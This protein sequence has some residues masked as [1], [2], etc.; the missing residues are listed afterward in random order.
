VEHRNLSHK[1]KFYP[2]I[3]IL[4]RKSEFWSK[5]LGTHQFDLFCTSTIFIASTFSVLR[6]T[7]QTWLR[8]FW[9]NFTSTKT[10]LRPLYFDLFTS[11]CTS[12][13]II[14]PDLTK[15]RSRE[16]EV[17]KPKYAS[18]TR[19]VE[20]ERSTK[21]SKIWNGWSTEKV[22]VMRTQNSKFGQKSIFS[23]KIEQ[24]WWPIEI[25]AK[26]FGQKSKVCPKV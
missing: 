21:R 7:G 14:S 22:E 24:I 9:S 20:V 12:Q 3:D 13:P 25:L 18:R 19:E 11:T 6:P 10:L 8:L 5:I 16:V 26:S 1:W 23:T 4:N 15:R 17:K 2:K